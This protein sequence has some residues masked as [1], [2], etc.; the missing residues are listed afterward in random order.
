MFGRRTRP[1]PDA[2][3]AARRRLAALAAEF[4]STRESAA[5]DPPPAVAQDLP[6][7]RSGRHAARSPAR[8][9]GRWD[10]SAHHLTILALAVVAAVAVAAWWVLRSVPESRPVTVTNER[11]LPTPQ[12]TPTPSAG[13]PPAATPSGGAPAPTSPGSV[14]V[15]VT[16]KVRHPGIVQL[17]AGSR[18]IDA[19]RQAGGTRPAVDVAGLN[20]A[21]VL[22]DGEQIVVGVDV[23]VVGP[24]SAPSATGGETI[25]QVNLNTATATE[26]ETLPGI[27]P[28]TAEAILAWR[29]DNGAFTTVDELL[30]VSGIGDAT[31]ADVAPYVYV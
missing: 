17:P 19:V 29:A 27:G 26:F 7:D 5:A 31:L 25:A 16:G 1:D 3:A 9:G 23:P 18:V 8:E 20:L 13:V 22:A 6:V 10:L 21:R 24:A 14:I 28:V 2:V 12:T 11:V 4:D 15:D 30:E